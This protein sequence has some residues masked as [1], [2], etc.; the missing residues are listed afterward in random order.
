MARKRGRRHSRTRVCFLH[1]L[2]GPQRRRPPTGFSAAVPVPCTGAVGSPR[3]AIL[4]VSGRLKS[5]AALWAERG[6]AAPRPAPGRKPPRRRG[7][8]RAAPKPPRRGGSGKSGH[9]N[10]RDGAEAARAAQKPPSC[11]GSG[12]SGSNY[13]RDGPGG[14][15]GGGERGGVSVSAVTP[16]LRKALWK[17]LGAAIQDPEATVKLQ[18]LSKLLPPP[19]SKGLHNLMDC[20]PAA[21]ERAGNE[22]SWAV[23]DAISTVLKN[24]EELHS[25]RRHLFSACVKG[26]VAMYSSSKD[27]GKQEVERSV[28]LRLEELLCV[29]EEVDPDDWC[30]LVKTG[31]KYR[32]RDE[33]FLKVLNVAI[34]LLYMKE[35]SLRA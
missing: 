7:G 27:E 2:N 3:A 35:S 19:G 9:R 33:T 14:A 4:R 21:P 15:R 32:Y 22:E 29:V 10:H 23:A 16:V 25:W 18:I 20:L 28:L 5:A 13:H 24:S 26:L 34:Q 30:D 12:K 17:E 31:L 1:C 6:T 8:A 11:G